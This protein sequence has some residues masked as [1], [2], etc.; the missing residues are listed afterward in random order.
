MNIE[1][2]NLLQTQIN[3]EVSRRGDN[4]NIQLYKDAD[5]LD[6]AENVDVVVMVGSKSIDITIVS[7]QFLM[8]V[9]GADSKRASVSN[10]DYYCTPGA[11][12][13]VSKIDAQTVVD[14]IISKLRMCDA[15][16]TNPS[17]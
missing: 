14:C 6:L 7:V 8:H 13:I 11:L 10:P 12:C 2:A 4:I 17:L 3:A 5:V 9:L 1:R 15:W 16:G